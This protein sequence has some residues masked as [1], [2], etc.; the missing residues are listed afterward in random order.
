MLF[1]FLIGSRYERNVKRRTKQNFMGTRTEPEEDS[2][3]HQRKLITTVMVPVISDWSFSFCRAGSHKESLA[4]V[5]GSDKEIKTCWLWLSHFHEVWLFLYFFH[6]WHFLMFEV[7]GFTFFFFFCVEVFLLLHPS[8]RIWCETEI[9]AFI[10][11]NWRLFLLLNNIDCK[12]QEQVQL[13]SFVSWLSNLTA[14][15]PQ[16]D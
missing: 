13:F 16:L 6:L 4:V 8:E 10:V 5:Q 15:Q 9:G 7:P 12:V 14:Q 2:L 11:L 3:S 1:I